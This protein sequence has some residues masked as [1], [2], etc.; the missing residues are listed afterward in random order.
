VKDQVGGGGG[1]SNCD[2]DFTIKD[3]NIALFAIGDL[4]LINSNR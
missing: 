2:H 1:G 3:I 4:D